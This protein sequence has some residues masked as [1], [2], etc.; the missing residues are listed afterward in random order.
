MGSLDSSVCELVMVVNSIDMSIVLMYQLVVLNE[1]RQM[2][3]AQIA[4]SSERESY[5][6]VVEWILTADG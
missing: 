1:Y 6:S 4:V 2:V 5:R 3:L